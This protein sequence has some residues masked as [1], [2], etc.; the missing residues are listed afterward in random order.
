MSEGLPPII[1][2]LFRHDLLEGFTTP[3]NMWLIEQLPAKEEA[4]QPAADSP[5]S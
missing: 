3:L 4:I 1:R 2:I 5:L